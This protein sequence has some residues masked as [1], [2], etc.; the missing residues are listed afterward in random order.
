MSIRLLEPVLADGIRHIH[1]F[2]RR[3]LTAEDLSQEQDANR[4]H[5]E[6]LGKAIGEGVAYGLEVVQA[7]A[8]E[9]LRRTVTVSPG[10]AVSRRGQ[11]LL[12]PQAADVLLVGEPGSAA[13]EA[14]TFVVCG[15]PAGTA[16]PTG[17]G[18]YILVLSPASE[19]QERAPSVGLGDNGVAR[20]CG[21]RYLVQGVQFRLL[22]LS[23]PAGFSIPGD[24][25][26]LRNRLA[27]LC[28]GTATVRQFPQD[29]FTPL[30]SYGPIDELRL[31]EGDR[32][33][34]DCDVP[35]ALIYWAAN[36][37]RFVDMWSVRRRLVQPSTAVA[38]PVLVGERRVAEA[39][40]AFLQFQDELEQIA[41]EEPD[42][43]EVKANEH[44][45]YLPPAGFLPVASGAFT[46]DAFFADLVVDR[47][48]IDEAALRLL[49][50]QSWFLEPID[51]L[52]PPPIQI[53]AAPKGEY[54]L[55]VRGEAQA[56][57]EVALPEPEP[58]PEDETPA[59]PTRTGDISITVKAPE[60]VRDSERALS[61]LKTIQIWAVDRRGN[62]QEAVPARTALGRVK[63]LQD[64]L[65]FK[66]GEARFIIRG[67]RP[68]VYT[69]Y[70]KASGFRDQS[71]NH[72]VK[73]GR[74]TQ[75]V[76][77]LTEKG[78]KPEGP[79][80][81]PPPGSKGDWIQPGW[82]EKMKL[83]EKH[84]KWPW[85]PE[86]GP[87]PDPLDDPLPPEVD[88]WVKDW[89]D[90]IHDTYPEAPVDPG[91][92]RVYLDPQYTPGAVAE[93]PYAF[94]V[95]G[96]GGA[97]M[98]AVLTPTDKTLDRPVSVLKAGMAGVDRLVV[99]QLN[100]FGV[101]EIDVLGAA[102]QGLVRDALEVSNE[103]AGGIIE[104]AQGHVDA[105]QGSLRIFG[106]V[107]AAV[108]KALSD[109][110]F[111][112]AVA[113]AN[114]NPQAILDA[115]GTERGMTLAFARRLIDEARL[116]VPAGA[117]SLSAAGLGLK[118]TE[119]AELRKAGIVTQA[120]FV[121]KAGDAATKTIISDTLKIDPAEV[122][123]LA[124]DLNTKI[125]ETAIVRATAP[126]T[127]APV[128]NVLGVTLNS[129]RTLAR[130][131]VGTVG[132]LAKAT[133]ESVAV[134]FGGDVDAAKAAIELAGKRLAP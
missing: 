33:L 105:L 65:R 104:E 125:G 75:V 96:H 108:E 132:A 94:V 3:L 78:K 120:D 54:V 130:L 115:V 95:F 10:L 74:T 99:E 18:V 35:L 118:D 111:G 101:G 11:A 37:V 14:G 57:A 76:F 53:Y 67:L 93:D 34:T 86:R 107:D 25:K 7:Q 88:G 38:W 109:S 36:G 42:P 80:V 40:A 4:K 58:A 106:G 81:K 85:P 29:P 27:H 70:L 79:S 124:G 68:D 112:D 49:L 55:F 131:G 73:A 16:Q 60:R 47:S 92:V 116:A 13:A 134:A 30:E 117:W 19:F 90:W 59:P 89:A 126:K 50:H 91:D 24:A 102:W 71:Q 100:A 69:V 98:P 45:R 66:R 17:T 82:Y 84:L 114:S 39:E 28:I 6:L 52:D 26:T 64:A 56:E 22:P 21:S 103:T 8:A 31:L 51:L 12:L 1:F 121:A 110:N 46:V 20:G 127:N 61:A 83:I 5:H 129:G 41:D 113:L 97:Y 133:P 77:N 32:R 72:E 63:N 62:A 119:I 87:W 15:T 123:R 48:E 122:D 44:F 23:V 43:A 128:T 9:D 2:N